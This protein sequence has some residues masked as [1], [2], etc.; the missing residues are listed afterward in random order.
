[1]DHRRARCQRTRD[2]GAHSVLPIPPLRMGISAVVRVSDGGRFVRFR[3]LLRVAIA[4]SF[5]LRA[6][7][8]ELVAVYALVRTLSCRFE[9]ARLQPR[10]TER[11]KRAGITVCGKTLATAVALKGLGFSRAIRAAKSTRL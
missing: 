7:S 4:R 10:C 6:M 9:R 2:P 5:G 1:M 11:L 8:S 3:F